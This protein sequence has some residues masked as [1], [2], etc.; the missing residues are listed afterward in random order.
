MPSG[1]AQPCNF[2][3]GGSGVLPGMPRLLASAVCHSV[4]DSPS[5]VSAR[6]LAAA[7]IVSPG[8]RI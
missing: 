1:Y 8:V 2:Y 4:G 3:Y 7:A 5:D 6:L